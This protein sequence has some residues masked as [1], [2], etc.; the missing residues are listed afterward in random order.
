MVPGTLGVYE[1]YRGIRAPLRLWVLKNTHGSF[2]KIG[3]PQ[4]V[5]EKV[6]L[7]F[8]NPTST[9]YD[10]KHPYTTLNPKPYTPYDPFKVQV[11]LDE[12]IPLG[13]R[14]AGHL[15]LRVQGL[16]FRV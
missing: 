13:G 14:R 8:G 3:E 5:S 15:G 16:G 2:P 1:G 4:K 6:L 10:P 11:H 7:I 12:T 9:L